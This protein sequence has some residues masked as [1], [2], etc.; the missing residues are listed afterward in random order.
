MQ[1]MT[2]LSLPWIIVVLGVL[3]A[4]YAASGDLQAVIYTDFLQGL[5][6]VIGGLICLSIISR[7]LPGRWT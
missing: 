6:L 5:S 2:G 4:T 3:V 7:L 1:T